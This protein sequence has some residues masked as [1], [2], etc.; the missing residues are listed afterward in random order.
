M[1]SIIKLT[2]LSLFIS[3]GLTGCKIDTPTSIE[4]PTVITKPNVPDNGNTAPPTYKTISFEGR[5]GTA[6]P[7]KAFNL[8]AEEEI[9]PYFE[10]A[11]GTYGFFYEGEPFNLKGQ[12]LFFEIKEPSSVLTKLPEQPINATYLGQ[13]TL[14]LTYANIPNGNNRNPIDIYDFIRK[15]GELRLDIENNQVS[16]KITFDEYYNNLNI[17]L[18][19]TALT[20]QGYH[21]VAY[22]P[23]SNDSEQ[24]FYE[25]VLV[26]GEDKTQSTFGIIHLPG[27]D[28]SKN[29]SGVFVGEKQ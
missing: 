28:Y 24:G 19:S 12:Q 27:K 11:Y 5:V 8:K 6:K 9:V 4:K 7:I 3:L 23:N 1:K 2:A 14:Q 16:G 10:N 18:K 20:E 25:G 17:S 26:G 13:A 22:R 21:G 29:I 15:T